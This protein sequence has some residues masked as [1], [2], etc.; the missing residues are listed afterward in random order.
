MDSRR[1]AKKFSGHGNFFPSE[2]ILVFEGGGWARVPR[3]LID[4]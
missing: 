1:Y 4:E 2:G 3:T